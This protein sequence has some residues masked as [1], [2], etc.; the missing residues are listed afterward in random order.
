MD[1]SFDVSFSEVKNS[2]FYLVKNHRIAY[3]GRNHL[4]LSPQMEIAQ[5]L[6]SV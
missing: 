6:C 1:F 5:L 4:K 2:T 3:V